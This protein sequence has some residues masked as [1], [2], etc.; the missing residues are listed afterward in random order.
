MTP[1]DACPWM[2]PTPFAKWTLVEDCL[3]GFTPSCHKDNDGVH[4]A[5]AEMVGREC[6]GYQTLRGLK[7]VTK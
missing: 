4:P 2:E 1:C 5:A 6:P 7:E 3:A